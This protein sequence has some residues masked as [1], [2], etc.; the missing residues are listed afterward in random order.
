MDY[1]M[2]IRRGKPKDIEDV[3]EL[4]RYS[5]AIP[6]DE[7]ERMEK[8]LKEID[9][10]SEFFIVERDG[11]SRAHARMIPLEQNVRSRWKKMTGVSMVASAPETRRRGY[12]REIMLQ[13]LQE[14]KDE[15]YGVSMLYPFKDSFYA[16]MG[17]VKMP[18][19]YTLTFNPR[20]IVY[21]KMPRD[22]RIERVDSK[23]GWEE[24]E[25]IHNYIASRTHGAAKRTRKR[26]NEHKIW[27]RGNL[28]VAYGPSSIPEGYMAYKLKGYGQFGDRD[29][30]GTMNIEEMLW[31]DPKALRALLRFISLHEDQIIKVKMPI[32]PLSQNYYHWMQGINVPNVKARFITMARIVDVEEALNGIPVNNQGS[33]AI[34]IVDN[35]FEWNT[36]TFQITSQNGELSVEPK[37]DSEPDIIMSIGSLT[38]LLYGSLSCEDLRGLDM[39]REEPPGFLYDW[40]PK[41]PAWLIEHF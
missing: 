4:N 37:G 16:S 12:V 41:T 21:S 24:C 20:N 26:W 23:T 30:V 1:S 17:Y 2:Q 9:V 25:E 33:I 32:T 28:V 40:F 36:Q 11:K 35:Q 31:K 10:A 13:S 39:L 8:C 15:G 19:W 7:D 18:P 22:Y 27:F 14:L 38:A 29:K 3:I 5:Y 6:S 34:R